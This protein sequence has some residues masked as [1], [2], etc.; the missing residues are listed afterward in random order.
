MPS[1]AWRST[2]EWVWEW[3]RRRREAAEER[4]RLAVETDR[5]M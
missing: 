2:R 4:E 1:R 3:M 5:P